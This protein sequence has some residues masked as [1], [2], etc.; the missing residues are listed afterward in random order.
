MRIYKDI[1]YFVIIALLIATIGQLYYSWVYRPISYSKPAVR[2]YYNQQTQ[3][4]QKL[5]KE[6]QNAD[7]F[8]YF[9]IYT[10]TRQD[11]K[12]ALLGAKY[13]GITIKGVVDKDQTAQ[14]KEQAAIIKELQQAGIPIG[15]QD[16]SAIMH[17]KTLVTEKSYFSGS[18]NWTSNATNLNDE[19]IEIGYDENIRKQYQIVLEELFKRYLDK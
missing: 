13:R 3:A 12:D 2:V 19:V 15:F 18:Y 7:Q 6:I 16:H 10:F 4:N 14:I 9:A 8:I 11:I 5:I 1:I 17:I